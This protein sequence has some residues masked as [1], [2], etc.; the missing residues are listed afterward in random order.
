VMNVEPPVVRLDRPPHVGNAHERAA[1][2]AAAQPVFGW[3]TLRGRGL[4]LSRGK[5]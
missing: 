1:A 3:L 4:G 2:P 5:W